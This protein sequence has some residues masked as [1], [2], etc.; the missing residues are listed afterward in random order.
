MFEIV[1]WFMYCMLDSS[2]TQESN[3]VPK[4]IGVGKK[5]KKK[6]NTNTNNDKMGFRPQSPLFSPLD[7]YFFIYLPC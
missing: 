5:K 7:S 6:K 1:S 3:K 2:L 4:T